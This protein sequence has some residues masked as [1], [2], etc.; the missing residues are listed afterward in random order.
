[1]QAAS[2]RLPAERGKGIGEAS[3]EL[4]ILPRHPVRPRAAQ[5][6]QEA[7]NEEACNCV[8]RNRRCLQRG[9]LRWR[10]QGQSTAGC[11]HERLNH[12]LPDEP[13]SVDPAVRMGEALAH[14]HAVVLS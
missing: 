12:L 10:G 8:A 9:W 5:Y 3:L 11:R 13:N 2:Y 4:G 14:A 7:S 1:M 6:L